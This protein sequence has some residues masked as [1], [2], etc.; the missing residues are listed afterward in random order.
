MKNIIIIFFVMATNVYAS[1]LRN[2]LK[3]YT[4]VRDKTIIDQL[5]KAPLYE[6]FLDIDLTLSSGVKS[7][8]GDVKNISTNSGTSQSDKEAA[9]AEI[10]NKNINSERYVDL[11]AI[12]AIALPTLKIKK[13]R[14]TSALFYNMNLGTL[15]TISNID[16]VLDPSVAVYMKKESKIGLST[17]ITKTSKRDR[18]L[19][20]NMYLFERADSSLVQTKSNLVDNTKVF[21]FGALNDGQK[22]LGTDIIW[23]R[24]NQNRT[25]RFEVLE[26]ST[27]PIKTVKDVE[28][29]HFPLFHAFHH[30]HSS[31][32]SDFWL[33]PFAGIHMRKRYSLFEG[34]YIGSWFKSKHLPFRASVNL[35][36]QFL[37]FMPEFKTDSFFFNYKLRMTYINPQN[38]IWVPTIHSFNLGVTF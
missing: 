20:V 2:N 33:E 9:I 24:T 25:Y 28:Y 18:S 13:Y 4:L 15:F 17:I 8:I 3:R 6:S 29:D 23:T 30:W 22:S 16:N 14:F 35:S 31:S 21:D 32:S 1:G 27:I 19:K 11:N 37:T 7:L 36:K 38:S 5:T 10:L 26:L 12:F 34:I